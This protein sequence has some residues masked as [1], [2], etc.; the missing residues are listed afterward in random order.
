MEM[1]IT[2]VT[3]A[4]FITGVTL[5]LVAL[6]YRTEKHPPIPSFNPKH[7]KFI[8][9]MKDDFTPH[10]FTLHMI[11]WSLVFLSVLTRIILL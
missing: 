7:W 5:A 9:N 10:G 3:F 8:W 1:W 4:V 2:F 11:G 6:K